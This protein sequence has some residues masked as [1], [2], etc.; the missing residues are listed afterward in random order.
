MRTSSVLAVAAMLASGAASANSSWTGWYIGGHAGTGSGESEAELSL[1][2]QWTTESQSLREFVASQW[3]TELDADGS[4]FGVH[5]GYR[6]QLEDG[7]VIGV[8]L[9]YS[10]LSIDDKRLTAPTPW[11]DGTSLTYSFGNRVE[12]NSMFAIRP[13]IGFAFEQHL[14]FLSVGW[15]AVDVDASA[16]VLSNGGYSKFGETSEKVSG[17]QWGVGYQ[18]AFGNQWSLRAEYLMTDWDSFDYNTAYRPDSTFVDPPY[19]ESVSQDLNLDLFRLGL[20]F[21]F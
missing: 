14:V 15:A 10:E 13:H 4:A 16:E 11:P 12:A 8:E 18:F 5:G 7:L 20:D 2:G 1:A 19:L 9:D 6:H 3:S 21:S 17:I